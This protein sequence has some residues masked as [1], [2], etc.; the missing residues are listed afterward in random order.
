M[1]FDDSVVDIEL[2]EYNSQL[3]FEL[4]FLSLKSDYFCL[5]SVDGVFEFEIIGK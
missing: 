2:F 4:F 3:L 5:H 1:V